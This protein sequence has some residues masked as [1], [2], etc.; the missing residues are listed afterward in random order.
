[1]DIK[2]M[3]YS[4]LFKKLFLHIKGAPLSLGEKKVA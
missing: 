3:K 2:S 4:L 1:M